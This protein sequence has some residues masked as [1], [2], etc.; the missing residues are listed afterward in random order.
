[1]GYSAE[2]VQGERKA[3]VPDLRIS[4]EEFT[5]EM[6]P[7]DVPAGVREE[8]KKEFD[9]KTCTR[10]WCGFSWSASMIQR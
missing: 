5:T 9:G 2:C 1:M 8:I 6:L 10:R 7:D 3:D 4:E